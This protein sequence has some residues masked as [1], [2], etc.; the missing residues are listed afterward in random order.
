[1]SHVTIPIKWLN[2]LL[3]LC[4]PED[5]ELR[6][7]VMKSAAPAAPAVDASE[8]EWL[9][10]DGRAHGFRV[11]QTIEGAVITHSTESL[12]AS[13]AAAQAAAKGE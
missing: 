3:A 11:L 6:E 9:T 10:K 13:I 4:G 5:H 1:M 2:E 12:R 8:L 7:R